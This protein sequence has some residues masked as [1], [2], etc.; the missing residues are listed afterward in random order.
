[1]ELNDWTINGETAIYRRDDIGPTGEPE[2][3]MMSAQWENNPVEL[4]RE[5]AEA[6]E[7]GEEEVAWTDPQALEDLRGITIRVMVNGEPMAM[8]ATRI[9]PD[10]K[11]TIEDFAAANHPE[12]VLQSLIESCRS[13]AAGTTP[14][15]AQIRRTLK[16]GGLLEETLGWPNTPTP[17]RL[18]RAM[19]YVESN[20]GLLDRPEQSAQSLMDE[21]NRTR[22]DAGNLLSIEATK[23]ISRDA[24]PR[25][26]SMGVRDWHQQQ[27]HWVMR[28]MAREG[29][30]RRTIG[31]A[32]NIQVEPG[33]NALG[34]IRVQR[35]P[36]WMGACINLRDLKDAQALVL[37]AE[38]PRNKPGILMVSINGHPEVP[39]LQR[40]SGEFPRGEASTLREIL[41]W[42]G[43]SE[44]LWVP[45]IHRPRRQRRNNRR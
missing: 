24:I 1:M 15:P 17:E 16:R 19:D 5:A 9:T 31:G 28:A 27:H 44:C 6:M 14:T 23:E 43:A 12:E 41:T 13:V 21:T 8:A 29:C 34:I 22:R 38:T 37:E 45:Q 26:A 2:N 18:Q 42:H 7:E 39:D 25:I 40:A 30:G 10:D 4:M 32:I 20:P 11:N 33:L 36:D 35:D 3:I